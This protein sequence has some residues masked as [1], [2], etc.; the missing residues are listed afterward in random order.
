MTR[1]KTTTRA[2]RVLLSLVVTLGLILGFGGAP[3][4]AYE[5]PAASPFAD[6][7][8]SDAAYKE[9]AWMSE[10]G[11]STGWPDGTYRPAQ[12]VDRDAMAAFIYRLKGS[13]AWTAPTGSPFTDISTGIQF[14]REM[15]WLQ[16]TEITTG[17]PDGT[18][19][20]WTQTDRDAMA[21][22][23]YRLAGRPD[24]TPPAVSPFTDITPDTQFYLEM[25]WLAEKGI[26]TGVDDGT[27]DPWQPVSRSMMAVFMYR[28]V[29]NVLG[30]PAVGSGILSVNDVSGGAQWRADFDASQSGQSVTLQVRTL[31]TKMT[32]ES[33]ISRWK[34][35]ATG[36]ANGSGD[37]TFPTLADPLEVTHTY[38][39]VA[40]TGLNLA[41][42]NEVSYAAPRTNLGTGLATIY[43]D[44]N[45]GAPIDSREVYR[46]GRITM[47]AG[48]LG[49]ST[50][51]NGCA[52][53]ASSLIKVRGRGHSTWDE[54]EKKPY[55]FSLDKKANLCGMGSAKKWALIA[56]HVDRSLLRNPAAMYLGS[57]FTNLAYTPESVPVDLYVNGSFK[58]SFTL[59]ER[60]NVGT[61]RVDIDELKDNQNGV[62]D[63]PPNVTGGYLLEW[64]FRQSGDNNINV[65]DS[66]AWVAIE[67]PENETDG[68]GITT[69]QI[70]YIDTYLA[71][72]DKALFGANF[73]D[74]Q[75]GWM[76][77]IDAAS[78]VDYY[79]AMEMLKPYDGNMHAS[80]KMYKTRDTDAGPGKLFFGPL[81]DFDIAM[82]NEDQPGNLASPEGWYLRDPFIPAIEKTQVDVS[83]FN[84]LNDDPQF[85]QMVKDRWVQVYPSLGSVHTFIGQ[86]RS[87][88]HDSAAE[89]FT[90]WNVTERLYPE[91]LIQGSWDAEVEHLD[92]W[93]TKRIAWMDIQYRS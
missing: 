79:I 63:S 13:P 8:L 62:N 42:S 44:T 49:G 27:F 85:Q 90:I 33:P 67:E 64:D 53:L 30:V 32:D 35:L 51:G 37:I 43:I 5:P 1:S 89:N 22:F 60:A 36:T 91:Q 18:Y 12:Q 24:Y 40:G 50:A 34:T 6:V 45:E 16:S 61:G 38:R 57:R 41:L 81:W 25:T 28:L 92:L 59:M 15:T 3:A 17:W 86:Q 47:T 72:A 21:A 93:L 2:R 68:S 23:I 19:R 14:F 87:L 70:N 11:I 29:E 66:G 48:S 71:D 74:D 46:E 80:V 52:D 55:N 39:A 10:M 69:A 84:R 88:I 77:Y 76:K 75:N 26:A 65:N 56:N 73:T 83:W 31:A 4:R 7:P 82:G 9:I 20:P 54:F 78:A 58:G